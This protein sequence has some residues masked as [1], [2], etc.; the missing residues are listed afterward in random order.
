LLKALDPQSREEVLS[1]CAYHRYAKGE[2]IISAGRRA[3]NLYFIARGRAQVAMFADCGGEVNFADLE[4]GAHF[5]ALSLLDGQ[6]HAVT[7]TALTEARV[8]VMSAAVLQRMLRRHPAAVAGLMAPLLAMVRSLCARI[9]EYSTAR[10]DH[11][12][13]AECL[14]LAE[15][16][17]MLDGVSRI[18]RMTHLQF[19]G[20]VSCHREAVSRELKAL[21]RDNLVVKEKRHFIVPDIERLRERQRQG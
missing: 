13:R 17:F 10:A 15:R 11:R 6:A 12:I 14:R 7:I 8:I 20:R 18:P 5:G 21:E 3:G 1:Q 9:L 16:C 19:A 2:R 4:R